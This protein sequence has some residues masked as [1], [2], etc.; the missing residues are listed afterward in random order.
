MDI[1][2]GGPCSSRAYNCT[3]ACEA[4][5]PTPAFYDDPVPAFGKDREPIPAKTARPV[6]SATSLHNHYSYSDA[7]C[8]AAAAY[9][10]QAV[11]DKVYI[12]PWPRQFDV[13]GIFRP[14]RQLFRQAERFGD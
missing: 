14:K 13:N 3:S 2:A 4:A 1:P 10:V 7:L 12:L 11:G 5:I 8:Q 9:T 6:D